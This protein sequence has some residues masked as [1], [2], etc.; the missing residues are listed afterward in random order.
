MITVRYTSW[1]TSL[2]EGTVEVRS[3]VDLCLFLGIFVG[4][5][6]QI[7][8]RITSTLMELFVLACYTEPDLTIILQCFGTTTTATNC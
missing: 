6:N 4:A 5:S 3:E 1:S 2:N 7:L 8:T